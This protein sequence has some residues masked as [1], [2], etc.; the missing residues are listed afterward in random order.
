M[1]AIEMFL[2]PKGRGILPLVR[3]N[4]ECPIEDQSQ[5]YTGDSSANSAKT[6]L[7]F[8]CASRVSR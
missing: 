8:T 3:A 6:D 1:K 5:K 4:V 2:E 7:A